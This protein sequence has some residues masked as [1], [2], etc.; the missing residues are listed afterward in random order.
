[1][2]IIFLI[3]EQYPKLLRLSKEW[4]ACIEEALDLYWT[5]FDV[6][7]ALV[8]I[9]GTQLSFVNSYISATPQNFCG[10]KGLRL[11]RLISC[12]VIAPKEVRGKT[13]KISFDYRY[14]KKTNNSSAVQ[15]SIVSL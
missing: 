8:R 7:Q 2:S 12:E 3:L 9:Y 10:R 5:Q 14:H 1:M 13:L 4:K 15:K 11:D 6:E